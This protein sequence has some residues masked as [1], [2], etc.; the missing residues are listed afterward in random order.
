[1]D[2]KPYTRY[3][4]IR[5]ATY[6]DEHRVIWLCRF[7]GEPFNVIPIDDT[8]TRQKMW[9]E[10][11]KYF[12]KYILCEYAE[13]SKRGVPEGIIRGLEIRDKIPKQTAPVELG[14]ASDS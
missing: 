11:D 4:S 3:F 10:C 9:R 13:Q 5:G 8:K 2:D 14:E 7:F 6:D 12:N 1:M